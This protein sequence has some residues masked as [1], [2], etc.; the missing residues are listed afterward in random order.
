LDQVLT[1]LLG[2]ALKFGAGKPV[3]VS[4]EERGAR[5][6]VTVADQGIGIAL[7]DQPRV[8]E[9]F[10]RA[11]SN[12]SFGGFGLGLWI[13]REFVQ[14]HGGEVWVE[15]APGAGARFVVELPR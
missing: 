8:F 9:R 5:A 6:R 3:R 11:V 10:E 15:S 13:V 4:V 1:N 2:N 7:E 14:A 12:R